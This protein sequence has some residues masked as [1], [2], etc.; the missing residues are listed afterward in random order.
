MRAGRAAVDVDR[1][2]AHF[3]GRCQ[4]VVRIPW[5]AHLE[6]G[7]L[8]EPARLT[9]ATRAAYLELAAHV[10]DGFRGTA[11]RLDRTD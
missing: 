10:A 5:D 3:A 7:S 8:V 9:T 11:G 6:A 4:A 2:E 1:V